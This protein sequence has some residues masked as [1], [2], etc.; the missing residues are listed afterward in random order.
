MVAHAALP[1]HCF[2]TGR[3]TVSNAHHTNAARLTPGAYYNYGLLHRKEVGVQPDRFS[4]LSGPFHG[5]RRVVIG[6]RG[7]SAKSVVSRPA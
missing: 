2:P 1:R 4:T 5:R 6:F 3:V 7:D